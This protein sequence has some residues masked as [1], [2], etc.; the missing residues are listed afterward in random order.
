[1]RERGR[2]TSERGSGGELKLDSP[3]WFQ[4]GRIV[5]K[6]TASCARNVR[7]EGLTTISIDLVEL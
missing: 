5:E 1:M 7:R 3:A 6:V 2:P 4:I